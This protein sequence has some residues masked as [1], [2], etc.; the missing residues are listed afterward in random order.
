[1]ESCTQ[2]DPSAKGKTLGRR[3]VGPAVHLRFCLTALILLL[4]A[5]IAA[6][7]DVVSAAAGAAGRV[8]SGTGFFVSRDGLVVTSAHVVAG[9]REI[10]V[11]PAG[12]PER[13]GR[14]IASN[15]TLDLAVLSTGAEAPRYATGLRGYGPELAGDPIATIG[16]GVLPARP[17]AP[18][19][20][21]GNLVGAVTDTVGNP[22]LLIR[23]RLHE[24][25]SGG[26]VIDSA[27]SLLG[28][29]IGRDA[30]HPELG[31]ATPSEAVEKFLYQYGIALTPSAP[32]M[33]EPVDPVS[34]LTPISVL[35]QCPA[36][37]SSALRG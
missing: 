15:T 18:V 24:G 6:T 11:W 36:V 13:F 28:V 3:R 9:C 33:N 1:M 34:L 26:P 20:T 30:A 27:G 2:P 35:V 17:R 22:I 8:K 5:A 37:V 32:R 10:T 7:T 23:A 29:V 21:N 14:I 4:L 19:V 12:L 25:N 31:V 16:F